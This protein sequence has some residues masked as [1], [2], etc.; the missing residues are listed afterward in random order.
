MSPRGGYI[1]GINAEE[2]GLTTVDLGGGRAKKGDSV[3]TAV[4]LVLKH[5]VGERVAQ[6]EP[7]LTLHA[8]DRAKFDAAKA[9]LIAAYE[10][11][12]TMPSLPPLIHK[13]I[14]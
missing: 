8:N 13:V 6:G 4:G 2:I 7:L 3:D 11:S 14:R 5:K 12:A 10:F 9:R 1:S